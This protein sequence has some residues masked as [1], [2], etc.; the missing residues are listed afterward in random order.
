[1]KLFDCEVGQ[2]PDFKCKLPALNAVCSPRF[3]AC[4]SRNSTLRLSAVGSFV[5]LHLCPTGQSSELVFVCL[6][7]FSMGTSP[8]LALSVVFLLFHCGRPLSFLY[9]IPVHCHFV[10]GLRS[11]LRCLC[12]R[13]HGSVL[14]SL[15]LLEPSSITVCFCL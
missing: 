11:A 3:L 12:A 7:V 2:A 1:M 9:H 15:S 10:C 14:S 13:P 5:C 6:W 8:S 4:L